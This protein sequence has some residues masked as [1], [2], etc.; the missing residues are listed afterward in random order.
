MGISMLGDEDDA[1][2]AAP[3]PSSSGPSGLRDDAGKPPVWLVPYE[4]IAAAARG[5]KFGIPVYGLQNWRRG[6][7]WSRLASPVL[8]HMHKWCSGEEY[9]AQSGVHHLDLA[10]SS[11]AMLIATV[12]SG[13]LDYDDRGFEEGMIVYTERSDIA[14]TPVASAG[15]TTASE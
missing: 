5:L 15:I 6:I 10:A 4:F 13:P 11:L 8:R 12:R 7:V 3:S 14:P 9:D 1:V 2:Q